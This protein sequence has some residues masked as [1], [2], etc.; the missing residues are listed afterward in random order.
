MKTVKFILALVATLILSFSAY[1]Q[2][3]HTDSTWFRH[4]SVG[5]TAGTDGVGTT[6]TVLLGNHLQLRGGYSWFPEVSVGFNKKVQMTSPWEINE[7]IPIRFAHQTKG[8]NVF[9]DIFPSQYA[10]IH[11]TIGLIATEGSRVIKVYTPNP[12]P[13]KPEEVA[14]TGFAVGDRTI[15][16][17]PEGYGAGYID[18]RTLKPYIGVGC[19]RQCQV[20]KRVSFQ[21][22]CGVMYTGNPRV[23]SFD[24]TGYASGVKE[25]VEVEVTSK[26]LGTLDPAFMDVG[27]KGI[28]DFIES[29]PV[30]L[31]MR[32]SLCVRLF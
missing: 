31:V 2:A 25:P 14:T 5:M 15:T 6:A 9:L 3:S 24:W 29:I 18:V 30:Q 1:A 27:E 16:S 23:Y 12:L 22:D 17:D 11:Y 7:K 26:D 4:W 13:I 21:F 19:G 28:I 20:D 32:F 10:R 8:P